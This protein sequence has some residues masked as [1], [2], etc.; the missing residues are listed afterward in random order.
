MHF[1]EIGAI[2]L[3]QLGLIVAQPTL[4]LKVDTLL[5]AVYVNVLDVFT[6]I[7]IPIVAAPT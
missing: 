3:S 1:L 7:L 5:H 6:S 4:D 2:L